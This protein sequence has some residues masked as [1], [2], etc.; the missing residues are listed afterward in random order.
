MQKRSIASGSVHQIPK[1]LNLFARA[2]RGLTALAMITAVAT[3]AGAARDSTSLETR[4]KIEEVRRELAKSKSEAGAVQQQ[5]G[6]LDSQIKTLTR[7]IQAK[8]TDISLLESTL[9]SGMAQI[10]DLEVDLV[11]T[12]SR[13]SARARRLYMTGPAESLSLFVSAKSIGEFIRLTR[14]QEMLSEM[15]SQSLVR[16]NRLKA[17]ISDKKTELEDVRDALARGPH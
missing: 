2:A 1:K 10:G 13:A 9:R 15:D 7:Q 3:P 8:E 11:A 5:I 17:D 4:K 16:S 12:Q 14:W 6:G